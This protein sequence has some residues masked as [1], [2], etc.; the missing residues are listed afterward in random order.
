VHRKDIKAL[1]IDDSEDDALLFERHTSGMDSFAVSL[2]HASTRQQ[3]EAALAGGGFDV[4]FCDLC[5][6]WGVSGLDIM[7]SARE[8]A[9]GVPFVI[10]TGA[11]DEA[12]A[13]E[14]MKNGAYDYLNKAHLSTEL[15]EKT[16]R[17]VLQ[18]TELER[19]RDSAMKK[20]AELSVTDEL[21]GI[22]NRRRLMEK[23]AEETGRSTRTNRPFALMMLDLDHFKEVNDRHGHQAG[24][25]L[26][27]D[28]AAALKANLRPIDLVARYGGDEFLIVLPETDMEN[29]RVAGERMR[30]VIKRL[31][32]SC[33][34]VSIGVAVWAAGDDVEAIM[35]RA[36][37]ALYEA[38]ASGRDC[39][40]GAAC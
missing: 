5:L 3:A 24:D 13:I 31:R 36:D 29:A 21:T 38:K 35:S 33:N 4:V 26:L 2:R 37:K 39:V 28:C 25:Q 18:R 1:L 10:V 7:R 15:I 30:E 11:S 9:I 27:R 6:D 20:L 19:E 16:I 23:L 32:E 8:H 22:A 40:A 14:A 34:T 17:W 12:R